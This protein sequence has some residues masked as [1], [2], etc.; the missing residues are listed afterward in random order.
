MIRS[1]LLHGSLFFIGGFGEEGLMAGGAEIIFI[2]I[3]IIHFE[4]HF[5]A[6]MGA[7][8]FHQVFAFFIIVFVIMAMAMMAAAAFVFVIIMAVAMAAA[9]FIVFF[10]EDQLFQIAQIAVDG[11]HV[12]I[13]FFLVG[14]EIFDFGGHIGEHFQ[15]FFQ[16]L[17]FV[18]FGVQ[19]HA[20]GQTLEVRNTIGQIAHIFHL[21][22]AATGNGGVKILPRILY[23]HK[24]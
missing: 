15:H 1:F 7:G 4:G 8:V 20:F 2:E 13:Q 5:F 18:G 23:F 10:A 24:V 12:F 14:A 9:A 16:Q 6:A 17:A 3:E 21:T 22:G 19:V 11:F